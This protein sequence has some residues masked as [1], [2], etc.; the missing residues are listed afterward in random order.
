M[1]A[2]KG[3]DSNTPVIVGHGLWLLLNQIYLIINLKTNK[4]VFLY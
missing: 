4:A 2:I 3:G 1:E